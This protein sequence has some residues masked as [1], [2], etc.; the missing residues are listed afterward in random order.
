MS[1]GLENENR[2][3]QLKYDICTFMH[4]KHEDSFCSQFMCILY[5]YLCILSIKNHTQLAPCHIVHE[6]ILCTS[7]YCSQAHIVNARAHIVH[8]RAH[9]V[10]ELI[11]FTSSCCS[12]TSS[13]CSRAHIVH[14]LML[15]TSSYCSRTSSYCSRT[16]SYCSRAH[17]DMEV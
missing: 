10:H 17:A 7:S 12:R 1:T 13:C 2:C 15:F 14:E 5:M 11:L 4:L 16:S 3:P 6:L 8:A 9:A